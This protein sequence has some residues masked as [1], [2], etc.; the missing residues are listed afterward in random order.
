MHHAVDDAVRNQIN[1]GY[2][3]SNPS[4]SIPL[5]ICFAPIPC[6]LSFDRNRI[7]AGMCVCDS[8]FC[9]VL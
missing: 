7:T 2:S 8:S 1:P 4:H 6:L 9:V 3:M 5:I